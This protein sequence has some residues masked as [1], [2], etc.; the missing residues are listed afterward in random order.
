MDKDIKEFL[1]NC[2]TCQDQNLPELPQ[3]AYFF[4][5][6]FEN[7]SMSELGHDCGTC[8]FWQQQQIHFEFHQRILK[9]RGISGHF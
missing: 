4:I 6:L 5:G 1:R 9:I 8:G 7:P 3:L 2:E